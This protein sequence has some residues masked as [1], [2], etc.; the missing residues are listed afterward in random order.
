ME[1][2]P[3]SDRK[4]KIAG[5]AEKLRTKAGHATFQG[6]SLRL[7][8]FLETTLEVNWTGFGERVNFVVSYEK[9]HF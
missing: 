8:R 6:H 1:S 3:L 2:S 9:L 5:R 7:V 4:R